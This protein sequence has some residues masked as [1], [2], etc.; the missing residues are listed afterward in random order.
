MVSNRV[1]NIHTQHC[2]NANI[3][4][5]IQG[6]LIWPQYIEKLYYKGASF[7]TKPDRMWKARRKIRLLYYILPTQLRDQVPAVRFALNTFVWAM[8]RL[9]GQVHCFQE[10]TQMKILPGSRSIDKRSTP[11]LQSQV[12]LG[13]ILLTGSMPEGAINPGAHHF[14]HVGKFTM[15]HSLLE[16]FWMMGFER[17]NLF[18]KNLMRTGLRPGVHLANSV[19][20][21]MAASYL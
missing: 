19:A 16:I 20:I 21:D 9:L 17:F 8:R 4:T 2:T 11:F 14:V 18:L 10:A 15:T 7:W 13:L 6:T 3:H 12:I 5:H 1:H